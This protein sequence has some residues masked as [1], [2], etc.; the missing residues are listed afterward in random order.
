MAD[1]ENKR[2]LIAGLHFR[3]VLPHLKREGGTYFVTFR[4]AGT[5]PK[6][7]LLRFKAER[8]AIMQQAGDEPVNAGLCAR[9]EDWKWSSAHAAQPSPVASSGTVPVPG[10]SPTNRPATRT[11]GEVMIVPVA[12]GAYW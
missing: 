9:P 3:G 2:Y 4:Q 7:V 1:S 12:T 10:T 5:L 8:E 11:G 6:E